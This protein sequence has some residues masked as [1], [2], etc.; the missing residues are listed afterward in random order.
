MEN[1]PQVPWNKAD[2][3]AEEAQ[4]MGVGEMGAAEDMREFVAEDYTGPSWNYFKEWW[5]KWKKSRSKSAS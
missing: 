4:E 1:I 5:G 3:A 2:K